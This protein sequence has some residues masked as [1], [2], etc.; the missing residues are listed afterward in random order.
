MRKWSDNLGPR[1]QGFAQKGL[2]VNS[3]ASSI[4]SNRS[5]AYRANPDVPS[6]DNSPVNQSYPL[7][8]RRTNLVSR[9]LPS[10]IEERPLPAP[11]APPL[12]PVFL[13]VP[14]F[15]SFSALIDATKL[16]AVALT[17]HATPGERRKSQSKPPSSFPVSIPRA[18]SKSSAGAVQP[19]GQSI[20]VAGEQRKVVGGGT[21]HFRTKKEEDEARRGNEEWRSGKLQDRMPVG[22]VMVL[23]LTV[24][25]LLSMS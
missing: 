23:S 4:I 2:G 24:S 10:R 12:P 1:E 13:E 19:T 18:V 20:I 8:A 5:S 22:K 16:S 17:T 15:E 7:P 21:Q 3:S 14:R 25:K 11:A 6:V 9:L